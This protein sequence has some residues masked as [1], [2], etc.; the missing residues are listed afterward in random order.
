MMK[1]RVNVNS[2]Y[3]QLF[4]QGKAFSASKQEKRKKG[5]KQ[6]KPT[7]PFYSI[8]SV[9]VEWLDNVGLTAQEGAIRICH[10]FKRLLVFK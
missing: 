2:D 7:K 9:N 4:R 10:I 6:H 1:Q 8:L 3:G 5:R